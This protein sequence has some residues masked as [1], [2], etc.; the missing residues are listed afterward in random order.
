MIIVNNKMIYFVLFMLCA[1]PSLA[2]SDGICL[3]NAGREDCGYGGISTQE[4]L[5]R[6][7]CYTESPNSPWCYPMTYTNIEDYVC[8][9][10]V[11]DRIDCGMNIIKY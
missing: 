9:T 7:C 5:D 10:D 4:C 11:A 3:I 1:V 8:P 2:D 6:G